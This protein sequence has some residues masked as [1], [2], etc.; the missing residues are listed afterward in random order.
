MV[1]RPT[2]RR[3][4]DSPGMHVCTYPLTRW[5]ESSKSIDRQKFTGPCV[6]ISYDHK[7]VVVQSAKKKRRGTRHG[8][9]RPLRVTRAATCQRHG[10]STYVV[11]GIRP[12]VAH[13]A[14]PQ[15]HG[16]SELHRCSAFGYPLVEYYGT[17]L[18]NRQDPDTAEHQGIPSPRAEETH[19]PT[20]N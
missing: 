6:A 4:S 20:H 1:H 14:W 2:Y 5:P 18:P 13:A 19:P 12:T 10:V 9:W 11:W 3:T 7:I 16:L 17:A 8:T 15:A